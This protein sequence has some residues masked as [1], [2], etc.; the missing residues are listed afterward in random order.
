M[1]KNWNILLRKAT[2]WIVFHSILAAAMVDL[3]LT[4]GSQWAIY[5]PVWFENDSL[6]FNSTHRAITMDQY[7][8]IR[9]Y[10]EKQVRTIRKVSLMDIQAV[11]I[12]TNTRLIIG[13]VLGMSLGALIGFGFYGESENPIM[14]FAGA[15]IGYFM[16][17]IWMREKETDDRRITVISGLDPTEREIEIRKL[18]K[19]KIRLEN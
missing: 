11:G 15:F 10:Q 19:G 6:L 18:L 17:D 7:Q 9:S 4:D 14:I 5:P 1:S 13:Q 3:T 2:F 12:S 16:M 8:D